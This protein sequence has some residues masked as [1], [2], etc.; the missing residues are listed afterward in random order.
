MPG[1]S[2]T[3]IAW[4]ALIGLQLLWF[5]WLSP[6]DSMGRLGGVLFAILPLLLPLWWILRL[7]RDGLVVGGMILLGYFCFAVVEA[8]VDASA[9]WLAIAQ[10]AL[11]TT[12][13]VALLAIRQQRPGAEDSSGE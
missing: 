8:W 2:V 7:G 11:I 12:Y 10:I 4:L 6:S 5:G 1:L 13:F 3:R 9:R